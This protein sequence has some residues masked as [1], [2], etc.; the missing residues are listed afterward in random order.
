MVKAE[1]FCPT[2]NFLTFQKVHA[3]PQLYPH[4][5]SGNLLA[6]ENE[7]R[8]ENETLGE[9]EADNEVS[10]PEYLLVAKPIV[11]STLIST[12]GHYSTM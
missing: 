11:S 4:P 9:N 7:I 1:Q 2:E 12:D 5:P 3:F 6:G 8:G 10:L